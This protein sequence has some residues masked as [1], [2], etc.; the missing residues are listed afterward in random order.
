VRVD[1]AEALSEAY[2]VNRRFLAPWDPIRDDSFFTA[3][4]QR[5]HLANVVRDMDS[6][7]VYRC[8][9]EYDGRIV[10]MVSLSA[11]ERGPAQTANLGYWV[12]EA[13]NGRGVATRAVGL[14][15]E[16]AFG[17]LGLHRLQAGTL[18]HNIA[19]QKVLERQGFERIGLARG[20]IKI[21]GAWQD[22]ILF[23]R[24]SGDEKT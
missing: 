16:T 5:V 21:A 10:G 20:F 4:G 12:A 24:I 2:R 19:S 7:A 11:I 13:V 15:V 18:V 17:E 23:Q 6:G 22:H 9:I 1:D 3:E 8:V 14:M